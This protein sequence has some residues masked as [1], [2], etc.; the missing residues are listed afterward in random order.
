MSRSL[1]GWF[2]P[3]RL[4]ESKARF[5]GEIPLSQLHRL[6]DLLA[7][8]SGSVSVRLDFSQSAGSVLLDLLIDGE[9]N[10][11]CQ[12]CMEPYRF[13]VEQQAALALLESD[14]T[15]QA[16]PEG[17]EPYEMPEARIN[18]AILIEDELIMALPLSPRHESRDLCNE[19]STD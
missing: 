17:Y 12:R 19:P 13:H 16:A 1:H 11:I 4:G 5:E 15:E 18:P 9:L 10:L 7:S 2:D 14:S 8:D 3:P 6:R